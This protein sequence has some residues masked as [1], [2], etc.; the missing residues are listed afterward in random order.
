MFQY[1][2]PEFANADPVSVTKRNTALKT[3]EGH[4]SLVQR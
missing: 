3:Y 4:I 2:A 1:E